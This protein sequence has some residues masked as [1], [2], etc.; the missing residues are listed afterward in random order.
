MKYQSKITLD[1]KTWS[2]RS[3]KNISLIKLMENKKM[4]IK[5]KYCIILPGERNFLI[6][7]LVLTTKKL[8]VWLDLQTFF[9]FKQYDICTYAYNT[10]KNVHLVK[11]EVVFTIHNWILCESWKSFFSQSCSGTCY[12][13]NWN[14]FNNVEKK[15][16][17]IAKLLLIT[18]LWA[19]T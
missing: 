14:C 7:L 8:K 11:S 1:S 13:G 2:Y 9:N 16:V 18:I 10:K 19:L 6:Q 17:V 3:L 4:Y 12:L 15:K 5:I